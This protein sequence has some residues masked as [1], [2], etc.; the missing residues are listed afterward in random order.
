MICAIHPSSSRQ[1]TGGGGTFG[2]VLD[3]TILATPLVTIQSVIVAF[4]AKPALTKEL[5]SIMVENAP[6]F[7]ADGWGAMSRA[8]VAVYV[9]PKLSK[10]DAATSLAPII[11]FGERLK[12]ENV[13]GATLAI[14]EFPTFGSYFQFFAARFG[15]VCGNLNLVMH[16]SNF[17][18]AVQWHQSRADLSPSSKV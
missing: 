16:G 3:A 14:S 1:K 4:G 13:T 10:A 5:W 15:S 18:C 2:V 7:V 12:A 8:N 6:Q 9:N 17:G 11:S